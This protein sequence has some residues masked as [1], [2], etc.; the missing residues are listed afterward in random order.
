MKDEAIW[1]SDL[2]VFQLKEV[3]NQN[4]E[5]GLSMVIIV[6]VMFSEH[7]RVKVS[8]QEWARAFGDMVRDVEQGF[9]R[10]CYK[11]VRSYKMVNY[12]GEWRG[13]EELEKS[14]C[15][16]VL[17]NIENYIWNNLFIMLHYY[18]CCLKK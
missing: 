15:Y 16:T 17:Y 2:G 10:N 14:F 5:A 3:V 12:W 6:P 7:D 11:Y 18:V 13:L 9:L 4:S 1:I 8:R